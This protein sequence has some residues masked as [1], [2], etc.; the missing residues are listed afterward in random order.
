[1]E[2][3]KELYDEK[4]KNLEDDSKDLN[5]RVS[6]LEKIYITIEK[7]TGEIVELRKDTNDM[8]K[9]L[10]TIEKEPGDKWKQVSSY[11]LTALIGA[12]LSFV[13]VKIG[14]K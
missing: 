8:N 12:V 2:F 7:L 3:N 6:A 4:I 1:M 11:I 14:L 9:R 5:K 10:T 13:L